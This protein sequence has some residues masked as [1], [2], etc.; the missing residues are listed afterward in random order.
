M[1]SFWGFL[2][3][4][5]YFTYLLI[6]FMISLSLSAL[7]RFIGAMAATPVHA[8]AFGSLGLLTL[9]LTSGFAIIRREYTSACFIYC[10]VSD[11]MYQHLHCLILVSDWAIIRRQCFSSCCLDCMLF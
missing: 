5:A 3:A 11:A 1:G 4:G 10:L 9:I 2:R 7:F 8:Q 6:M